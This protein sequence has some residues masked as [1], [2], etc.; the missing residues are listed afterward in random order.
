MHTFMKNS[1]KNPGVSFG[2]HPSSTP[3]MLRTS[4]SLGPPRSPRITLLHTGLRSLV[5]VPSSSHL[6]SYNKLAYFNY[7]Q[8]SNRIHSDFGGGI[9]FCQGSKSNKLEFWRKNMLGNRCQRGP[10]HKYIVQLAECNWA[11]LSLTVVIA[12]LGSLSF[13]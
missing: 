4:H 13:I 6:L 3:A 7:S 11:L 10:L 12:S 8:I 5:S 1:N 9:F 2:L